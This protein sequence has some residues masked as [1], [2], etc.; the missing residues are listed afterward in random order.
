MNP[1]ELKL[2]EIMKVAGWKQQQ[3]AN[4]LEASQATVS[5]W[6]S[7]KQD[8]EGSA[9]DAINALYE[10]VI[11]GGPKASDGQMVAVMGY[12]GAGAEIEPEYEQTPPEGLDQVW[13]PFELDDDLIAF[14]VR[15]IS[16][17]PVYREGHIVVCY[18]DQKRPIEF[19][20]GHDAVVRISDG[21]RFIKTISRSGSQID[22]LSF[23]A[24]PIHDVEIEWIGEI[25]AVLPKTSVK[26]LERKGGLQGRLFGF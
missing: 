12:I 24:L 17:M 11:E 14:E 6:L 7:G 26:R 20:Y 18:K 19:F 16:M 25:F 23:N 1:I 5:R 9:R 15:G 13:I 8:P 10:K 4:E 22:L 3:L 21:R 2:R